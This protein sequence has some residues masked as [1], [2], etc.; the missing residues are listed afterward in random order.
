[1]CGVPEWGKIASAGPLGGCFPYTKDL[2]YLRL[3]E[4]RDSGVELEY[5]KNIF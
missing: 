1:M 3:L 5:S 2:V 4:K